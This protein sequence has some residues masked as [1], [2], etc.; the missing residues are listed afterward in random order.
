MNSDSQQRDNALNQQLRE[1]VEEI[2]QYSANAD[3]AIIRV[4]RRV[5]LNKFIN[6]VKDK[7]CMSLVLHH[8][9]FEG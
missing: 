8:K 7:N 9:S 5:A 4:K 1:L 6:A 3:R 2:K